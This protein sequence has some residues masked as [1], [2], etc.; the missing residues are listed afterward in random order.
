MNTGEYKLVATPRS[1]ETKPSQTRAEDQVPAVIYG[2]HVEPQA[3]S[4]DAREFN[5]VFHKAGASSLVEIEV[6]GGMSQVVLFKE[7]QYDPR[8]GHVIHIDL[9]AVNM[10]EKIKADIP[11]VFENE[12]PVVESHEAILVTNKDSIEVECLPRDLPH[13]IAV[14]ISVLVNINDQIMV[15]DLKLG[16]GIE[17]LDDPEEIIVLVAEQ[18]EEEEQPVVSEAE[19]VAAVQ[20]SA[21]KSED[22]KSE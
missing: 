6:T 3:I 5:R 19:A 20:A 11:L 17:V 13:N 12:S 18:R 4:L 7:P 14:D 21:E 9:Y 1:T 22:E 15:K 10:S 2:K 8:D 16:A